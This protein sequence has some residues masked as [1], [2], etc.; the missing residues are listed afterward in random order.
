MPEKTSFIIPYRILRALADK[1]SMNIENLVKVFTK[2][3]M[4]GAAQKDGSQ[5]SGR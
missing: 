2:G 1:Y 5:K 3:L 4:D